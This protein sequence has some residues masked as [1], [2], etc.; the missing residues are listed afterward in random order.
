M[1]YLP[2]GDSGLVDEKMRGRESTRVSVRVD[3]D[4]TRRDFQKKV[5]TDNTVQLI[6]HRH[7]YPMIC[8]HL[9]R[10]SPPNLLSGCEL[11]SCACRSDLTLL[12]SRLRTCF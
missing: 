10:F 5:S 4:V 11:P 12:N 1:I 3:S 7:T 6:E 2:D 9:A 8:S